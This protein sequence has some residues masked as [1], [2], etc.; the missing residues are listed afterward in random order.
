MSRPRRCAITDRKFDSA[1]G[2]GAGPGVGGLG[3]GGRLATHVGPPL[4]LF[5]PAVRRLWPIS[6]SQPGTPGVRGPSTGNMG[7]CIPPDPGRCK[8]EIGMFRTGSWLPGQ[9]GLVEFLARGSS[10]STV[11]SGERAGAG[12][13][14][15]TKVVA[16]SWPAVFCR[17]VFCPGESCGAAD[18][19]RR[20]GRAS[21]PASRGSAGASPSRQEPRPPNRRRMFV[22]TALA[23]LPPP[24]ILLPQ[25]GNLDTILVSPAAQVDHHELVS[26]QLPREL[27]RMGHGVGGFQ[28]R[29]DALGA[30]Q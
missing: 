10:S 25:P 17:A 11:H 13:T 14:S 21:L 6:R 16:G 15:S 23:G 4:R 18:A 12:G 8:T 7:A 3:G 5:P 2:G 30:R 24:A 1:G 29:Y 9:F 19:T 27:D 28:R 26:R 20:F 22:E